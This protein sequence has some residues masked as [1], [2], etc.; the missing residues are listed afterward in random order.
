MSKLTEDDKKYLKKLSRYIQSEGYR[1]GNIAT[2]F[3]RD[4]RLDKEL[5][6]GIPKFTNGVK[7]PTGYYQILDKILNQET[8]EEV[9]DDFDIDEDFVN[10]SQLQVELDCIREKLYIDLTIYYTESRDKFVEIDP[11]EQTISSVIKNYLLDDRGFSKPESGTLRLF[12][13]GGGD[14]GYLESKFDNGESVPSLFEDWC[15]KQLEEYFG[16]WEIDSGSSGFFD[17]DINGDTIYINHSE[18]YEETK[19]TT[20]FEESFK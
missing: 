11:S 4:D 13:E 6:I 9:Y 8:L 7:I 19:S 16:G 1:T 17:I 12:Y 2:W 15:Y 14:S 3:D 10:G 20:I 5:I 18:N